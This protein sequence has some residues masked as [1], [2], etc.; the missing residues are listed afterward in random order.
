MKRRPRQIEMIDD[1]MAAVIRVKSG[2]ER[3]RI[4]SDMYSA[5]RT[6]LINHLR[7]VNPD[8]S[9]A[10]VVREAARRLSHESA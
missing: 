1:A 10:Q 9:E 5:A 3:L 4:A 6:M 2:Q 7:H 8:W